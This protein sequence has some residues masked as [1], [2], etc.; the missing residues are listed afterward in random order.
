MECAVEGGARTLPTGALKT[1]FKGVGQINCK[2]QTNY[3]TNYYEKIFT[4]NFCCDA[5]G[6]QR[7]GRGGER[8]NHL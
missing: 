5:G 3:K 6:V 1:V 4:F 7:A 8:N 2:T